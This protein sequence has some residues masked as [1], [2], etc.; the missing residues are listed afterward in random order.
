[1]MEKEEEI[2]K[3]ELEKRKQEEETHGKVQKKENRMRY[4]ET[5]RC[6]ESIKQ[7]EIVLKIQTKWTFY[8]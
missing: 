5:M 4:H 8:F 7:Y 1:M 6:D 2:E 3:I